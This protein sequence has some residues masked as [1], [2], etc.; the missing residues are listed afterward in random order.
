MKKLP[1]VIGCMIVKDEERLIARL[2][3]Y[4]ATQRFVDRMLIC[5][6][7]STDRTVEVIELAAR[8]AGIS[9]EVLRHAWVNFAHNR[10][11]AFAACKGKAQ[12]A[13]VI[14]ADDWIVGNLQLPE[15]L[16]ADSYS[17]KINVGNSHWRQQLFNLCDQNWTYEDKIHEW[18]RS[19]KPQPKME[20]LE[21][22]YYVLATTTGVRSRDP[23]KYR[24]DALLIEQELKKRKTH[25][26]YW[27][28]LGNSWR[29]ANEP[30]RAAEAYERRMKLRGDQ[31]EVFLS[32]YHRALCL[33]KAGRPLDEALD[34]LQACASNH[35]R[36]AE[37]LLDFARLLRERGFIAPPL[38]ELIV[39]VAAAAEAKSAD[40][41]DGGKK[42]D[43]R[44][45]LAAERGAALPY[46]FD[47]MLFVQTAAYEHLCPQEA[48]RHAYLLGEFERCLAWCDKVL[49]RAGLPSAAQHETLILRMNAL[50]RLKFREATRCLPPPARLISALAAA[51]A[52]KQ[53]AP[54]GKGTVCVRLA[55]TGPLEHAHLTMD[56][57]L[58]S[59]ADIGRV[60]RWVSD[61]PAISARYPFFSGAKRDLVPPTRGAVDVSPIQGAVGAEGVVDEATFL[62]ATLASAETNVAQTGS[63]AG[64]DL[65]GAEFVLEL[66]DDWFFFERQPYIEPC[67]RI[68]QQQPQIAAVCFCPR[69]ADRMDLAGIARQMQPPEAA[70]AQRA[71]EQW[72]CLMRVGA[73]SGTLDFLPRIACNRIRGTS[74]LFPESITVPPAPAPPPA[75]AVPRS[76]Q[77]RVLTRDAIELDERIPDLRADLRPARSLCLY[78]AAGQ[79][80]IV[81]GGAQ[82][83]CD[84]TTPAACIFAPTV[85]ETKKTCTFDTVFALVKDAKEV[86]RH[87]GRNHVALIDLSTVRARAEFACEPDCVHVLHFGSPTFTAETSG[88]RMLDE[89]ELC[90]LGQGSAV[91][92]RGPLSP[93]L[94]ADLDF[95]ADKGRACVERIAYHAYAR[96]YA[97]FAASP[98]AAEAASTSP[99]RPE[100]WP[101]LV[102]APRPW[103]RS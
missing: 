62:A 26:R 46:P 37:P 15:R 86:T 71:P 95:S 101:S 53:A 50:E 55:R 74:P 5:D 36:R 47:M 65:G 83:L 75:P 34:A 6:T 48:A 58:N 91:A 64:A 60:T 96:G 79:L 7:G 102:C 93:V 92:Y 66:Q 20:R 73:A 19:D 41:V 100:G 81:A 63:G 13:L 31:E 4:L 49:A 11:L 28:Y 76:L 84:S 72:P 1:K 77:P 90:I 68:M 88:L 39:G 44:G 21:G 32:E 3:D 52:A 33:H 29:D 59:C 97:V 12:L 27:F 80:D 35:P 85:G 87:S 8:R 25:A 54:L 57:F 103:N 94:L 16:L 2:V 70:L 24:N 10:S 9:C 14:D 30:A 78:A 69:F 99:T 61:D 45:L 82:P 42:T 89:H 22:D 40:R 43:E 98:T 23:L 18:P 67:L 38:P 56:S 17:L 51:C